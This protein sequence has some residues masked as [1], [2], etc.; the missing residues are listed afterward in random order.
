MKIYLQRVYIM[1]IFIDKLQGKGVNQYMCGKIAVLNLF[2]TYREAHIHW[3]ILLIYNNSP[4]RVFHKSNFNL[5][6]KQTL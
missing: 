3:Y 2:Y 6:N 5:P 1:C 4:I